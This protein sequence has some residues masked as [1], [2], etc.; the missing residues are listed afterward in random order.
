MSELS[1]TATPDQFDVV[2]LRSLRDAPS[3]EEVLDA[4]RDVGLACGVLDACCH[5]YSRGSGRWTGGR[6]CDVRLRREVTPAR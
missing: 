3:C 1:T 4:C 5:L 2:I 6:H